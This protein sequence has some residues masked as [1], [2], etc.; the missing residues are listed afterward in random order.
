MYD[1]KN[2]IYYKYEAYFL[3]ICIFCPNYYS[4]DMN[5][6]NIWFLICFR[7]CLQLKNLVKIHYANNPQNMYKLNAKF[8]P[9]CKINI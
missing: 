7:K 5:V 9:L 4:Y 8:S 2:N 1:T 3:M 6:E